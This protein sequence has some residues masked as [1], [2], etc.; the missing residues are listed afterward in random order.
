MLLAT[1][2]A[3]STSSPPAAPSRGADNNIVL[4]WH[5]AHHRAVTLPASSLPQL[6]KGSPAPLRRGP[7]LINFWASWCG[8]CVKE[9]PLLERLERSG[10]VTVLGVTRDVRRPPA[11]EMIKRSHVS[12]ANWLDK[13]GAYMRS[14]RDLIPPV[15]VPSSLLVVD[16]RAT[17]VHIGPFRSWRDL[18]S[19]VS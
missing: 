14:F 4:G 10:N 2:C 8:P 7:V 5:S 12:Y 15:A 6:E 11:L 9:L 18:R 1:A 17:A 13:D 19:A 16:G 3:P